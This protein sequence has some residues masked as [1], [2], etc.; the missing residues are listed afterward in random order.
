MSGRERWLLAGQ[1]LLRSG[2]IATVK[3]ETLTAETGLTTGSFYHHFANV[4]AFLEDLARFFGADQI[5][6][7]LAAVDDPDPL[8]RLSDLVRR[9]RDEDMTTLYAAM[10]TWAESSDAARE[11]VRAADHRMLTFLETAFGDLGHDPDAARLR[12]LLFMSAGVARIHPPWP[13]P[14]D[15]NGQILALLTPL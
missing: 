1:A 8:A 13:I 7:S 5:E 15:A 12:A 10:R 9:N 6:A 2:G 14:R 11:A 4:D 3:L